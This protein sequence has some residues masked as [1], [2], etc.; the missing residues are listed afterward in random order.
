MRFVRNLYRLL[1]KRVNSLALFVQPLQRNGHCF[2]DENFADPGEIPEELPEVLYDI[3]QMEEMLC[4]L[5]S[6][7]FLIW[8]GKGGQYKTRGIVISF[9][10]DVSDLYST[11]PRLP[12]SV[13]LGRAGLKSPGLGLLKS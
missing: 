6:P 3:T 1:T 4:S 11:H 12:D 13:V 5:A 10:Q 8:V 9:S 7:C 2:V